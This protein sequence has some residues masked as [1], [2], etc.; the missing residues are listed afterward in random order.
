[1][2]AAI[3]NNRRENVMALCGK[4][5]LIAVAMIVAGLSAGAAHAAPCGNDASGFEAWKAAFSREAAA[6]GIS[7]AGLQALAG[8]FGL[9]TM[10]GGGGQGMA[11]IV[12][13]L[14]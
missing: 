1:M 5:H 12:E 14:K 11:M 6:N 9:E 8:T 7:Q 10:C 13:R 2:S 3:E 4:G